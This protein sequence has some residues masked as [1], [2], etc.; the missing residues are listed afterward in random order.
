[1][2]ESIIDLIVTLLVGFGII[3]FTLFL[4]KEN[5]KRKGNKR[6]VNLIEKIQK[7][8]LYGLGWFWTGIKMIFF[9]S[10]ATILA[11]GVRP[12]IYQLNKPLGEGYSIFGSYVI[13]ICLFL[14]FNGWSKKK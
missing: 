12:F 1:M 6:E 3:Y 9:M 4:A 13:A 7:K 8:M 2:I 11:I 5:R 10:L 14:I